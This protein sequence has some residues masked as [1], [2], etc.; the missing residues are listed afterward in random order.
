VH[1]SVLKTVLGSKSQAAL[2]EVACVG[3][4]EL[5]EATLQRKLPLH[6]LEVFRQRDSARERARSAENSLKQEKDG[7]NALCDRYA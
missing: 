4:A 5:W 1:A 2:V 3:F 6:I 7:T